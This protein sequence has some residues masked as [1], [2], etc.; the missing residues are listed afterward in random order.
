MPW[1]DTLDEELKTH[2]TT[3][4]WDKLEPDKAVI[5]AVKSHRALEKLAGV[6]AE[7]LLRL[8]DKDDAPE[9]EDLRKRL[10]RPKEASEY[11]FDEVKFKDG[12]PADE[13]FTGFARSLAHELGL[14]VAQATKMAQAFI[15]Y[16]DKDAMEAQ[17]ELTTRRAAEQAMLDAQWGTRKD[18]NLFLA[19]KG[20]EVMGFGK[21]IVDAIEGTVGYAKTMEALRLVGERT[22]EA[23][24]LRGAGTAGSKTTLS[25]GEARVEIDRLM[26]DAGW[27][28]K[29][30][31]GDTEAR[32]YLSD[33]N[34][35]IV[36]PPPTR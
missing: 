14:P 28:K 17:T 22:T 34:T 24:N 32:Q 31:D 5:E 7:R 36:G 29:W 3:K 13:T 16:A 21:E 23:P 18:V 19:Q 11:K 35:I 6:P 25:V 26:K 4:G 27:Q 2:A 33:L 15:E 30:Y 1:T 10:P 9:W 12:T 8:P 20:A